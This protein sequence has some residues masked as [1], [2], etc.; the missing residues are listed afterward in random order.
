MSFLDRLKATGRNVKREVQAYRL[1][2]RHGRT[3]R[4]AKVLLGFAVGY[5]L[6]PFDLIPDFLPIIG[7]L[8][9]LVI[10]PAL[11]ILALEMVPQGVIEEC[12]RHVR[13]GRD[14]ATDD[15]G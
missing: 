15:R 13:E 3:P 11:V 6:L 5:L 10:V 4:P 9:D 12:R 14:L 7:H 8:D 1:I 2:L